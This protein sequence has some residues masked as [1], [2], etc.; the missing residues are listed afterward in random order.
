LTSQDRGPAIA[1]LLRAIG[2]D[3]QQVKAVLE[4]LP[5][6][7]RPNSDWSDEAEAMH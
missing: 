2:L 5:A 7:V 6:P 3:T 1:A 4:R